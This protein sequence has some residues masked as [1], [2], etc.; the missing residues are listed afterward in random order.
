MRAAVIAHLARKEI[1]S[2]LRDR[3]AIVSNL[4][5][6]FLLLP[7]LMLGMP[8]MLG[9]LFEREAQTVSEVGV[10][11]LE[12][13]P[14]PLV[15]ALEDQQ[16][17]L[18]ASADP[19]AAVEE[20]T[21]QVALDVPPDFTT[22]LEAGDAPTLTLYSRRGNMRSELVASKVQSA[23]AAYR[24]QLVAER[25]SAAGLDAG[26][27]EPFAVA[28][29]DARPEAERASGF[30]A[31]LIPFCI[32]I[33]TLVGGQMTAIDATA[34]EKERG[35]LEVLLVA[36][37]RRAEV[38]V[39]K[40]LATMTFGLAAALMAILGYVAGGWV[41]RNVFGEAFA[42]GDFAEVMGGSLQID[43]LSVALLI[44]SSLLIAALI[45]A[46]L[47]GVTLFARS[48]KE[49]Q[50]YVA[51]L[52]FLLIIP[53]FI[54]QFADFFDFG[55]LAYLIP[56]LNVMLVMDAIVKGAAEALPLLV[57]WGSSLLYTAIL[58]D[59]AYRNF[60]REGVIFRT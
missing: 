19:Y 36:P 4:L 17:E 13:L 34:G 14:D 30:M 59:F 46:L 50:T 1:L 24:E 2:T 11:G 51:P 6:P 52:S 12:H 48:F 32:V 38:V 39:G 10:R 58:L 5:I 25:L 31:W 18:V 60:K 22:L 43:A 55:L 21:F 57:T 15:R 53:I 8:F 41:V 27:L 42:A 9:G 28:S 16:I 35:T 45:A 33:W 40:F 20:G 23:V 54:L 26:V 44:V 47:I 37:V 3:R 29:V 49:A 56:I 7:V